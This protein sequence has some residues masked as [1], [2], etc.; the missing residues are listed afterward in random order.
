MNWELVIALSVKIDQETQE[1][2]H[3]AGLRLL[4]GNLTF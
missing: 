4:I 2:I 3:Q 1:V